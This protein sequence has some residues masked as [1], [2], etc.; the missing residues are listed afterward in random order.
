LND[1]YSREILELVPIKLSDDCHNILMDSASL[2]EGMDYKEEFL[3]D[4]SAGSD[5]EEMDNNDTN[6]S[7]DKDSSD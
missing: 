1:N 4:S 6:T 5:L 7:S 3:D 2:Q